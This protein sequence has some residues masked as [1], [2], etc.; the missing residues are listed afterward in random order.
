MRPGPSPYPRTPHGG[1]ALPFLEQ[2]HRSFTLTAPRN[3]PDP[4]G[5]IVP[6]I[7]ACVDAFLNSPAANPGHR[8]IEKAGRLVRTWLERTG[9]PQ[10]GLPPAALLME[11]AGTGG[12]LFRNLHRDFVAECTEW[13]DSCL[14]TGHTLYSEAAG[15]WTDTAA[16][17]AKAGKAGDEQCLAQAGSILADVARIERGAMRALTRLGSETPA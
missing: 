10:R 12:A 8:G 1:G 5:Q 11:E 16:L 9:H 14:R 7:T 17:I 13:L 2:R 4:Y 15:L 6:N 3:L